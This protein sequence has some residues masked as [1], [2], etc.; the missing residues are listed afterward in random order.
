MSATFDDDDDLSASRD[1][2]RTLS[3][4]IAYFGQL[5]NV[6]APCARAEPIFANTSLVNR[7]E[8]EGKVAIVHRDP[9]EIPDEQRTSFIKKAKTCEEAGAVGVIALCQTG[10]R[11]LK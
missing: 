10:W 9:R 2:L 7:A 6:T 11:Q 8:I 5:K 1:F 4:G 3:C